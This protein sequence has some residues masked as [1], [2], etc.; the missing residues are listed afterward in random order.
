MRASR[1]TKMVGQLKAVAGDSISKEREAKLEALKETAEK[2]TPP[3]LKIINLRS[4]PATI[5]PANAPVVKR[6][7]TFT[8]RF[9]LNREPDNPFD[10]EKADITCTVTAPS[11]RVAEHIGFWYQDYDR[12]DNFAG[13]ELKPMGRPEWRIRITPREVGTYTYVVHAKIQKDSVDTKPMTFVCD[14]SSHHGFVR[15]SKD[16]RYFEFDNGDFFYPI[17]HNLH[18]PVDIRCWKEIFKQE[19]PAGRGLN[20]YADFFDKMQQAGENTAE[21]WMSSWWVGIEWTSAW[22]DY[23]GAQRYSLQNAWKLDT[24]LKMARDH[25][26][27]IHLVLDN[28]GKFSAFCDWEWD[29][30]PYNQINGGI[31]NTAPEFFTDQTARKWHRNRLRYIA[32]RWSNDPTIMGWELVSEFDLVGGKN[33]DDQARNYFHRSQIPRDWAHEMI[34]YMRSCD[35]YKHL[36]TLH[37]ASNYSFVDLSLAQTPLFDYVVTDA[38]RADP[39]Y[40]GAAMNMQSWASNNLFH[41]NATKPFWITEFGGDWNATTPAALEAD[42]Y[43]G[44]WST[45][46]TE[47]AGTPMFWWYD[48]IDRNK[49]YSYIHAFANYARGEDRRGI[50]GSPSALLITNGNPNGLLAGYGFLWPAGAYGWVFTS[51]AM[52]HMPPPERLAKHTGVE[53]QIQ[54]LTPGKYIAEY[55]DCFEGK[56]V[57]TEEKELAASQV[58]TLHFPPFISN[59]A[60]KIKHKDKQF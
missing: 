46:M 27:N 2:Y 54:S 28:H 38:Y 14:T 44:P 10:P 5:V 26:L 52:M 36:V 50:N 8:V 43:C 35:V 6:Y 40:T 47:G 41:A 12:A 49:L 17:G 33:R 7:D 23:Y 24:L 20:M 34:N 51:S 22:R 9:E 3:P 18:S 11:G 57:S 31:V 42:F 32:A 25:G 37:Y 15:V 21:V 56:I 13:D 4:D 58:F 16:P 45:W 19:P 53:V 39:N 48:F 55:W 59:M 1:F 29:L 30:N 60:F